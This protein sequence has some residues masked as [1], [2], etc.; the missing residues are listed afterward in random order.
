VHWK[1]DPTLY[2]PYVRARIGRGRGVREGSE[3]VPWFKVRDV[4][5]RGTSA[6]ING[7]LTG[8]DHHLLSDLEAIYF[9]LIERKITTVDIREQWPILDFDRT[10]ELCSRLGVHHTMQDGHPVPFTIDFLI[11][12]TVSG[13]LKYRA[14]SVKTPEDARDPHVRLRL[15][16]EYAWCQ[17]RGIP[18]TLV[19]TRSFNKKILQNF[20]FLRAWFRH[21]YTPNSSFEA[22]FVEVF[23]AAY[24]PNR[25]LVDLLTQLSRDLRQPITV[26]E[27][28][29]RYCAW[30]GQLRASLQHS[31]TLNSPVVLEQPTNHA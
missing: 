22:R 2:P 9:Y 21:R 7:V 10:L 6:I 28:C 12:E 30:S 23:N 13:A 24:A 15:A 18:W 19:D 26:M 16:V 20:H 11:T 5:S 3:Y 8:R 17:E 27:D 1:P 14:A 4:P 25:Q 29:F 31:I